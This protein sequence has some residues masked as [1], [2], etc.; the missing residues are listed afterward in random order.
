MKPK[1]QAI[2]HGK[3]RRAI[4]LSKDSHS[5]VFVTPYGLL[6]LRKKELTFFP[7]AVLR[8]NS[9]YRCRIFQKVVETP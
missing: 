8:P 4:G 1:I 5:T 2:P 9:K 7:E 3:Y 6:E